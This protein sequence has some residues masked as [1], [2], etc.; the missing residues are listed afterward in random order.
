MREGGLMQA[1]DVP[2]ASIVDFVTAARMVL[3]E[4]WHRAP[5]WLLMS[6]IEDA[7]PAIPPKVLRAK[8]SKLVKR[9]LLDGC[10]CGCRGDFRLPGE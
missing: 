6:E 2:D 8:L 9:G 7:F 4:P 3:T 1:K 10:T 5:R